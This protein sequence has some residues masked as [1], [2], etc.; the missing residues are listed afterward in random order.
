MLDDTHDRSLRSWVASAN[1]PASEFPIQNLP[2]GRFRRAR[3][4]ERLR[5]G[6]AIGDQILDL[7]LA[8][9][10]SPWSAAEQQLLQPLADGDLNA[11]M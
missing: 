8:L 10:N 3:S 6:I 5:I 9:D 1:D 4:D 11:F 2:F 7:K